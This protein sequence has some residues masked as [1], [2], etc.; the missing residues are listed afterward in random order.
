MT[1]LPLFPLNAVLF[2]NT[3]LPLHIFEERYR[4][5]V[6]RCIKEQLPFGVVYNRGEKIE[7]IGC[8]AR[9]DRVLK[10]Y[11]D[12]R[13]DIVTV[14]RRRFSIESLDT[15]LPYLQALVRF[16]DESEES[17]EPG[18]DAVEAGAI[19]AVLRYSFYSEIEIDRDA[20]RELTVK[21]LSFLIAGIDEVGLETKQRLLEIDSPSRRLRH[22]VEA[23][24][25][26]TEQLVAL[27]SLKKAI[28]DDVD[29][30]TMKN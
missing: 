27:M 4:L 30:S 11:D 1:Q 21:E 29:I 9:I 3:P 25:K 6:E 24:D 10:E 23:L 20:L 18:P 8:S 16:L 5:L 13:L 14:G 22:A 28:G 12:G 26:V 2:P 15:S 7:Q 17:E 19:D